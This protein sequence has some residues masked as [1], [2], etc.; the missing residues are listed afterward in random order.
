[1]GGGGA[2]LSGELT[3]P[4]ADK[5]LEEAERAVE[6]YEEMRIAGIAP[7]PSREA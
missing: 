4:L 1:L 6:K 7:R 3:R 2:E 5:K